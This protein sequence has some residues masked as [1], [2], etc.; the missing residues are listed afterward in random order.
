MSSDSR[1]AGVSVKIRNYKC[2]DATAAGFDAI[3]P[4]NV[5]VG[6]NNSGKSALLDLIEGASTNAQYF[7][8]HP[9]TG[10]TA[11]E[12]EIERSGMLT[13]GG[14]R[15]VFPQEVNG[16]SL[17]SNRTHWEIGKDL[18]DAPFHWKTDHEGRR[19]FLRTD[20][21]FPYGTS[22][23]DK[24]TVVAQNAPDPFGGLVVR[25][26]AADRDVRP[27]KKSGG[28]P[29]MVANGDGCTRVYEAI[30]NNK[31]YSREL[32]EKTVLRDLQTIMGEDGDFS[33]LRILEHDDAWEVMLVEAAKGQI[34]LSTSGSG[35]KTILLVLALV[36][37]LPAIDNVSLAK[38]ILCLEELE[39]NLHPAVQRRLAAYLRAKVIEERSTVFITTH[40][41]ALIDFFANDVEAQIIHVTRSEKVASCRVVT[42]HLE[43]VSV[44]DDLQF[45][46]SDLLQA[47]SVVWLEGPSD[48]IYFN[49]WI[50]LVTGGQLREG[51]HYQ[52]SF[53]GGS[54]LKH[55]SAD[56]AASEGIRILSVNRNAILIA[57]R[58]R[59]A[60]DVELK[61]EVR[62]MEEEL[63]GV[64]GT[65]WVTDGREVENYL[66]LDALRRAFEC[67]E[68]ALAVRR[69]E[70]FPAWVKSVSP[71]AATRFAESKA[72][73]AKALVQHL[74]LADIEAD[75]ELA[76][77]VRTV[78][79]QIRKWNG[80][81]TVPSAVSE[82][83]PVR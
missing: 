63:R 25:R 52:C 57:D 13:A 46:A 47:N 12:I 62:R 20:A 37:L 60:N 7:A 70:R 54:I 3:K 39:N 71:T 22:V 59:D 32:I 45:R 2:F 29:V 49:R 77:H 33:G 40:S 14:V 31:A 6:R 56:P 28:H 18:L 68:G 81:S 75:A 72:V 34:A 4:I 27:E 73:F 67:D 43:H 17:P 83:A 53:Y 1:W 30:A 35:L 74:T 8:A 23:P 26:L 65:F 50:E 76:L 58:D 16:G 80:I 51:T 64:G 66:P 11:R 79:N 69:F 38:T 9:H 55:F 78:A 41:A 5:I 82:V 21:H 19:S 42:E 10:T 36:H 24:L 44:L 15:A 61:P 48:R